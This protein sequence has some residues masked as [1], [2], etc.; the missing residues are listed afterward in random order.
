MNTLPEAGEAPVGVHRVVYKELL[1]GDRRKLRG[2]SNDADTG[3]GARDL[4]FPFKGFDDVFRTLLPRD[5]YETRKRKG[6]RTQVRVRKG[7]VYVDHV[8]EVAAKE[9]TS[10]HDMVWEPPTNAR[11]TEGRIVRVHESPA[12][13]DLLDTDPDD[14][15]FI[16]FIQNDKDE[17]RVHYAYETEL[18]S[19]VWAPAVAKPILEHLDGHRR[20]NVAVAG[21]IDFIQKVR[22]AHV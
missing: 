21:Y 2:E 13:R 18:R 10:K 11:P 12:T 4:R 15:V 16:L 5:G 22:Y 7:D 19:G 1:P 20:S 6:E 9:T 17:L 8:D 3:G 14:R